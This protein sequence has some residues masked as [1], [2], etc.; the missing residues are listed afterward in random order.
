M[1]MRS[2]SVPEFFEATDVAPEADTFS[3]IDRHSA[4]DGTF[5]ADRDL[6][7]EGEVKGTIECQGTLFVAEG[8]TVHAQVDAENVTVAGNLNGE[9]TCHGR[10]QLMPS[11]QVR[12]KVSTETLV[13][14][15]GAFYEG[16]LEM[17]A[18]EDR[19]KAPR[20]IN[21]GAGPS[22]FSAAGGEGNGGRGGSTTFIRRLG[23]PETAWGGENQHDEEPVAVPVDGD[24][25]ARGERSE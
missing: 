17:P 23:Q 5:R 3:V 7:I 4:F 19:G 25:T 16:Q 14:D 6:R 9:I 8:A 10:L 24:P 22:P 21:A 15:E 1:S 12:G 2:T 13:I 20:P 11:G 18:P